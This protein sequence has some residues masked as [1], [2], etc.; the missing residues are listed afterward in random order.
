M[1]SPFGSFPEQLASFWYFLY[2][3]PD[4]WTQKDTPNGTGPFMFKSFTPGQ[5][6]VFVRNTN[7]WKAGPAR[8]WTRS[9]SWTSRTPPPSR[10]PSS[11]RSS[12]APGNS[13]GR[14]CRSCRSTPGIMAVPSQTGAIEPFTMRVDKPP[15]NDVNV[16]Q[17][18]R[19]LIDRPEFIATTLDGFG[20]RGSRRH[21]AVR[22]GLRPLAAP[23]AGH[24]P[25]QAPAEEGRLRQRPDRD[26]RTRRWPSTRA[27]S[28]WRPSSSSRPARPG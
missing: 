5:Q 10:T 8:T 15:F 25:G 14:R 20:T 12:T 6:S 22:P 16:R 9:R 4:G 28:T 7:Y 24:R 2:I 11:A 26:P 23:R 17:A 3:A 21:V 1:T 19:Y 27:R 13:A 18:F